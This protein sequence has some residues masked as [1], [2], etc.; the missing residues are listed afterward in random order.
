MENVHFF[1][2]SY[3]NFSII[4]IPYCQIKLSIRIQYF[5]FQV[6]ISDHLEDT[7]C[8]SC[9]W[10][11]YS[12]QLS[13]CLIFVFLI[14]QDLKKKNL[15][16]RQQKGKKKEE[17]TRTR[18]GSK[19]Q[20]LRK[21]V[22]LFHF[23]DTSFIILEIGFMDPNSF[24]TLVLPFNQIFSFL[25][26][27][28]CLNKFS[29]L[30]IWIHQFDATKPHLMRRNCLLGQKKTKKHKQKEKWKNNKQNEKRKEMMIIIIYLFSFINI[31]LIG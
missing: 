31:L 28:N 23:F 21:F 16:I 5:W 18:K 7:F 12:E 9:K 25:L 22:L 15:R 26:L 20:K 3:F 24:K 1:F 6:V 14:F 8:D 17:W 19:G 11:L 10:S 30:W 4:I 27:D 29:L 13:F 2:S